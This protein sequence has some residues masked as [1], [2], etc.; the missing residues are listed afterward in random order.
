MVRYVYATGNNASVE[1]KMRVLRKVKKMPNI[2]DVVG[3]IQDTKFLNNVS[4]LM[5]KI[6]FQTT[7]ANAAE[8]TSYCQ[9]CYYGCQCNLTTCFKTFKQRAIVT[10]GG[11]GPFACGSGNR[12]CTGTRTVIVAGCPV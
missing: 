1:F 11:C 9:E 7:S 5:S 4:S 12:G 2:L 6:L 8:C 10:G 3:R